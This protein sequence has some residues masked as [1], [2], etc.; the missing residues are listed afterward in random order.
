MSVSAKVIIAGQNNISSAVNGARN[1][2]ST[3]AQASQKVGDTLKKAFTVTAIVA[4]LK[5]LGS[6][7][8]DCFN[9]FSTATRSYKQLSL[10]LKDNSGYKS[11]VANIDKLSR[12][13]L[14]SKD[15]VES[16]VSEL[17]ALGKSSD[18]I[19]RISDAAVALSNVTGKDL[20]SS[21]TTLLN[22]YTG[23]VKQLK[24]LGVNTDDLTETQL[25][26]GAAVDLVIQKFYSLSEAMAEADSS[27]HIQN[28][29]NTFG[30]IKQ[31]IGGII[32]YNIAPLLAKMD[33]GLQTSFSNITKVINYTGAVI[34]NF[35]DV[36]KQS[37][38]LVG[39]MLN[40]VFSWDFVSGSIETIFDNITTVCAGENSNARMRKMV[41]FDI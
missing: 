1:D 20:N 13:T 15:Q 11:V 29:K 27:Q 30:D 36:A 34:A 21:M 6:V 40:T 26:N 41:F 3:L 23:N 38:G 12:M 10:A 28:I 37:L 22:T 24:K 8:V 9:D 17:A 31:Q 7:C 25:K 39:S 33:N 5:K 18:E 2:L 4:S 32:E 19:N 35:P 16:M 14:E